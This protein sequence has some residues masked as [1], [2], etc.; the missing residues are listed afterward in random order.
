M[1]LAQNAQ[2]LKNRRFGSLRFTQKRYGKSH[3][4]LVNRDKP[5]P[6]EKSSHLDSSVSK[7]KGNTKNREDAETL[8]FAAGN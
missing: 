5:K 7:R 2:P 4:P 8:R 3:S 6:K 1:Q